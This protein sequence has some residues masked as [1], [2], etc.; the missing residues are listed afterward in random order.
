[1]LDV[2]LETRPEGRVRVGRAGGGDDAVVLLHGYPD[3]LRIW[4]RLA[5]RLERRRVIAFDWPGMGES[6]PWPG[7]TTPYDMAERLRR[8][9]DHWS[10]GRVTLVAEDMGGQAALAFAA[11]HADR[12]RRLVIM[13]SLAFADAPT[14]WEIRLLRKFGWNRALLRRLPGVVFRRCERTFLPRGIVLPPE[15]R[16]DLWR[17]FRRPATRD[18]II[19]L[20]AGYEGSLARLPSLYREIQAPTLVLWGERDKHF[21]IVHADRLSAAVTGARME[22]VP[23]GEHWMI[24]H[25]AEEVASRLERFFDAT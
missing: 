23:G 20:C 12:L 10:L 5:E 9:L 13:N 16:D 24:W 25:A 15:L 4:E 3:N 7:G 11:R 17:C 21:P 14:S 19:R 22:I 2:R 18:F 8:L 6:D 1:M